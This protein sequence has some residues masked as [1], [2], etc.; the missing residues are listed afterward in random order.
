MSDLSNPSLSIPSAN[1]ILVLDSTKCKTYL[2]CPR[3]FMYEHVLGWRQEN[4]NIHL[5]FGICWHVAMEH[6]LQHGLSEASV[7]E[8]IKLFNMEFRGYYPN[9]ELVTGLLGVK[10]PANAERALREYALHYASVDNFTVLRTEITGSAPISV[11]H[12]DRQIYYRLDALATDSRGNY[13]VIDHKTASYFGRNFVEQ[14]AQ[15][16]QMSAYAFALSML[17]GK[18]DRYTVLVNAI[19]ITNPPRLRKDGQPYANSKTTEVLR[20]PITYNSDALKSWLALANHLYS[21]ISHDISTMLGNIDSTVLPAFF[22][23]PV[24]CVSKYG[25]CPYLEF[26]QYQHNP[27]QWID[28]LPS[29]FVKSYWN[30]RENMR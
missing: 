17:A 5:A 6:L 10:T 20:I 19:T 22:R 29:G 11:T 3:R 28:K 21:E 1:D 2:A 4:V 12:P 24:N 13:F 15:D 18:L 26:C 8:A 27:L 7:D 23:N 25:I 14:W 9:P 30:P 16:F